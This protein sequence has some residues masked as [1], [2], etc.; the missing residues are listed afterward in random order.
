[1]AE[2]EL[3]LRHAGDEYTVIVD[4]TWEKVDDSFDHAFGTEHRSH[5][6]AEDYDIVA[7]LNSDG[8]EIDPEAIPGLTK[9]VTQSLHDYDYHP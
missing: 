1:V 4:V 3:T 2:L 8:E 7:V 9:A 5:W 6:E